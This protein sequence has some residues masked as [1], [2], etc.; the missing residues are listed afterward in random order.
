[1]TVKQGDRPVPSEAVYHGIMGEIVKAIK[2]Q[3]E[4]DPIAIHIQLMVAIGNAIGRKPHFLAEADRHGVNLS[5]VLV[6]RTAKG[7]KGVAKGHARNIMAGVDPEWHKRCQL[8]S[9]ASGEGLIN[10]VRDAD[11]EARG[12]VVYHNARAAPRG[13]AAAA[14]SRA[15]AGRPDDLK[16]VEINCDAR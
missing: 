3:S 16:A 4:A 9:L 6:G 11:P 1:M 15:D 7:R 12:N 2:P 5:V 10:R 13:G 8:T 14:R